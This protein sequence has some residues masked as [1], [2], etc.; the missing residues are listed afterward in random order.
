MKTNIRIE[1]FELS[2]HWSW[3]VTVNASSTY[4]VEGDYDNAFATAE[5]VLV[6]ML[7]KEDG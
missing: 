6:D 1:Y 2:D 7:E 4:G 3:E 5:L